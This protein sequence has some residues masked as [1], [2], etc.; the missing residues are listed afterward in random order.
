MKIKGLQKLT[1]IDYP[2]KLACTVFLF[3][4]NFRCGFCHNPELVFLKDEKEIS[5]EELLKFLEKRKKYL[6]AVCFTGGEPLMT[7]EEEFLKKVKVLGYLIKIDT[8]GSFPEKLK[9]FISKGL[10][11]FVAMDIKAHKDSYQKICGADA[12]I[13]KIEESIKIISKLPNY[14]FR[15]TIVG[16]YHSELEIERMINWLSELMGKKIK[17]FS[18]QGFKK[19]DKL[20]DASFKE[21]E[22]TKEEFLKKLKE[23]IQ[24]KCGEVVIRV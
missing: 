13:N 21:E 23:K 10:V 4:C 22:N 8:N 15:T 17:R 1:L 6:D 14:E 2:K 7:L 12:D 9:D 19:E 3:G 18:L 24:D 5:K 16:R 11:D 20:I